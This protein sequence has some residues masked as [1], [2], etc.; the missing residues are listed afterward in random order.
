MSIPTTQPKQNHPSDAYEGPHPLSSHPFA[1]NPELKI[2]MDGVL[3]P[4]AQATISIFDHGLLYG[5]GIFEGI[6]I[7][8]GKIFKEK[9]HIGRLFESAGAIRLK[10]PYTRE[11]ISRGMHE[12][13]A[14]N[15]VV[16][17]YIR[18]VVTR[19]VGTLGISP[20]KTAHPCVFVIAAT[21]ELYPPE[22]YEKGLHVITSATLR[23]HPATLSPRIKSLNYLNNIIAKLEA[24][25][26]GVA[27]AVMLNH[28]GYVAECTGDNIFVVRNG[29]LY[30]PPEYAG[31]LSGI[32]RAVVMELARKRGMH[33]HERTLMRHDLYIADEMFVT[34]T[35]AEIAPVVSADYR[36][37]GTGKPGEITKMLMKDFAEYRSK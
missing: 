30:T 9:E 16:E 24:L 8:N 33:V 27:E 3:K 28:E 11:G 37:V 13:M 6:R 12:A 31:I 20:A 36:P 4:V 23:N 2:W 21:I 14:A 7:Y 18:L 10:I 35:A 5:D 15:N 22:V 26:A 1:P 25:D 32:T 17:G 19:G 34:G 29:E